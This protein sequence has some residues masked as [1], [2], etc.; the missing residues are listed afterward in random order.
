MKQHQGPGNPSEARPT[1]KEI[2][3]RVFERG[4]DDALAAYGVEAIV[5][6]F[7]PERVPKELWFDL[8]SDEFGLGRAPRGLRL[9]PTPWSPD[10]RDLRPCNGVD[11]VKAVVAQARAQNK[12]VRIAGSQHSAPPAVLADGSQPSIHVKLGGELRRVTVVEENAAEG[13]IVVRA[14]AGCNLGIDPSDPESTAENS[15][16]RQV[17]RLGYALPILGGM[18]HQ[19]LGGFMMTGS[20]GGSLAYGFAD[21]LESFEL[22][23]GRGEVRT[24][25]KGSDDFYAAGVSMGLFG[26]LTHVTMKLRKSYLV[27]GEE[28]TVATRDSILASP[29]ALTAA[30][31]EHPYVHA[32]WFPG[33]GVDRVLQFT[34][35]PAPNTAPVVPYRHVLQN[36]WMSY[37]AALALYSVAELQS[38]GS[39]ALQELANLLIKLVNPIGSPQRFSD[40][41]YIAL[42][43]DDQALID[44]AIRV[45][46]TEVWL[47]VEKT[48][49]VMAALRALFE[50]DPLAGGNFGVEVYGAKASPFWLSQS[51]GRD[52]VR[53]DPYWWEYNPRGKLQTFFAKYWNA[54]LTIP[55]A[56]LHWG[57]H[58]PAVGTKFGDMTMGPDYVAKAFPK[59]REWLAKRAAY[60]PH[61]LFV[62]SYWRS[63]LGIARP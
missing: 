37:A 27:K 60:D 45:Q 31:K 39:K 1:A 30:F 55:T 7:D 17:D 32:V 33:R 56:R 20:A 3:D 11:E 14:G 25:T 34:A 9:G 61:Q 5:R 38:V 4:A 36:Y 21:V 53:I 23:D 2:V 46:F 59:F 51:Y 50:R 54:L 19:T 26:V 63:M 62:T 44:T 16:N 52:V 40:R 35:A 29:G 42:P 57:K 41:W 47:D 48:P 22:V 43:N 49:E 18:S 10:H 15:F 28:V 13:Y 58:F 6:A 12:V 24:L 8:R